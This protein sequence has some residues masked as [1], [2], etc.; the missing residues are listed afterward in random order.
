[1]RTARRII[2]SPQSIADPYEYLRLLDDCIYSKS[3]TLGKTIH[4]HLLK[5]NYNISSILLN[6]LTSFYIK[7]N[8]LKLAR[9]VFDEIP[10]PE[11][12]H[13]VILWNQMIRAYAWD[14]PFEQAI[15][16]YHEMIG[17][18]VIPTKYTYP[19]VLKACSGLQAVEE[20]KEIHECVKRVG[21][22]SDVYISTALVDLYAKCGCLFDA[23]NVFDKMPRRDV[24]AWN[25]MIAASSLH[26]M[27]RETMQLIA[28]M[29]EEGLSPNSSTVVA[30]LPAIREANALSQGKA[31]HGY[32]VRRSFHNDVVVGTGLLDMYA[33]CRCLSY[34]RTIFYVMGVDVKN[35]V[36][37]SAMIGACV[38]CDSASEAIELFD[39]VMV[40][41]DVS[42]SPVTLGTV[43]RACAKINDLSRGRRIHTYTVKSG[44]CLDLMVGNTLVSMYAKCGIID[45]ALR[46]FDEMDLKDTVSYSAVISGCVQNGNAE[47]ALQIFRKMQFYRIDPD[48]ATMIGFLP[49]CSHLAAL[50]HGACGH[51]YSIVRGFTTD[52]S[53]CNAVIDMYCKCGK[54]D[55]ARL[56][57]DRMHKKDI[58]SWNAMIV[59]YGLHGFGWEAVSL[60]SEMQ[61]VNIQPDDVSFIGL[62]SAC[63]HSGLVSEGKHWF[64]A[65]SQDFNIVP[66]LEHYLCMVD[67]LG[68]AGL[69]NEAHQFIQKM[70]TK[71]DVRIWSALLAAC[72]I[73]RNLELGEEVSR[74]IQSL[75][76]ESTGNFVLLSNIYSSAGR[77]DDAANVRI[78]QRDQ[79]FKKSPGCSWVE[80][81]GIVH[82]F[83]GG[84]RSHPQS[85][86]IN[87]KLE[88][89]LSE[90]KELGYKAES[91]FVLHD[92][93][94]EEK[95]RILLFHSE[96]LAVAFGVISLSPKKPILVTKNLRVCGDCHSA[97]K[98]ISI[99]TKRVIIVRDASRF[100][101]FRDG[102]CNCGDFW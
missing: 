2:S 21:L 97:L 40:E 80:I 93:E 38:T 55:I 14:G 92:V 4:Q 52:I 84:D 85:A 15:E 11:K 70:P 13:K 50:Q 67:L 44:S 57:F 42:P 36:T 54:M 76:P 65:M 79:G 7:F 46:F 99:I 23:H 82:A 45:D 72:K 68:R 101:H 49:A 26:G 10:Q 1:M 83:V 78:M 9:H 25:A 90:M 81:N 43:L 34:A 59:G 12:K 94:E 77:F 29:Q 89:F 95:E 53:I 32:C 19:F 47:E 17:T 71:P 91:D 96:K 35:E 51:S 102:S 69:L 73:H 3:L 48:L 75:G 24:V 28:R 64:V 62:L 33:K 88:E 63:S 74:N 98:Y 58:I 86:Q 100:H 16:L 6:K 30:I 31:V 5:T 41:D 56:V 18:G 27:H 20:G 8:E 61:V 87:K 39:N 37:W 22:E 66:R 60:F